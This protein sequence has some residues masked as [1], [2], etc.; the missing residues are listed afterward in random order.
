MTS[1]HSAGSGEDLT[2]MFTGSGV[3]LEAAS[4]ALAGRYDPN[5]RHY[6]RRP[7]TTDADGT[8]VVPD[9]AAD[10]R[11]RSTLGRCAVPGGRA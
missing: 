11:T 2:G 3:N 1:T 8:L 6:L 9:G 7:C 5:R 4:A 10:S